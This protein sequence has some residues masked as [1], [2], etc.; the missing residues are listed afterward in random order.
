MIDRGEI[1]DA[2]TVILLQQLARTSNQIA[3]ARPSLQARS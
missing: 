3:S 2:K 1:F